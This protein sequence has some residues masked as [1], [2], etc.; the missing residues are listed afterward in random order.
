MSYRLT[1]GAYYSHV[2]HR[3]YQFKPGDA[4]D[5]LRARSQLEHEDSVF[6][7]AEAQRVANMPLDTRSRADVVRAETVHKTQGSGDAGTAMQSRLAELQT[8]L[9]RAQT[10]Q[11]K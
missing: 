9:A 2:T 10:P 5:Q 3:T 11:D 7:Q 1:K 8:A 6:K 4:I